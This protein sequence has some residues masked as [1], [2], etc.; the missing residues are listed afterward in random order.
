MRKRFVFATAIA[1]AGLIIIP[2][3]GLILPPSAGYHEHE[4]IIY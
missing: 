1:V 4:F 2:L 3:N